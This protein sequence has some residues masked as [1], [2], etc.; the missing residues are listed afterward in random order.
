MTRTIAPMVLSKMFRT[1]FIFIPLSVFFSSCC[2]TFI[3]S[4]PDLFAFLH[5][6]VM[7]T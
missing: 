5:V 4:C 2:V 6:P 1:F 3:F 7:K